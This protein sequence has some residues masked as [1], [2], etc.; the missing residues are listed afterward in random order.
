MTNPNILYLLCLVLVILL[1]GRAWLRVVRPPQQYIW[2]SHSPRAR[3][4]MALALLQRS[5]RKFCGLGQ[6]LWL[7]CSKSK[8]AL[9]NLVGR[10]KLHIRSIDFGLVYRQLSDGSLQ[11]EPRTEARMSG[12]ETLLA[13][14]PW[15]DRFDFQMFLD[16][17]DAG[18]RYRAGI[19]DSGS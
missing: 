4:P 12:I 9:R 14:Y 18:E 15:M 7:H 3:T 17:F 11:I 19:S 13:K 2:R 6:N 8:C 16:G 10:W 1:L 5:L